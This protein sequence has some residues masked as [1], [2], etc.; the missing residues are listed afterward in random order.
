MSLNSI[1]DWI[2][3]VSGPE[4]IWFVKYLSG[5][6]TLANNT[7]Q[8]GPY[9]PN[10]ILFGLFPELLDEGVKN[11]DVLLDAFIDSHSDAKKV[12]VV[13]YNQGTRNEC[14]MTRWGGASSPMLDPE[15]TG[16]L[17]VFAFSRSDEE[18]IPVCRIW[19]CRHPLEEDIVEERV[20][21]VE[22]GK[23]GWRVWSRNNALQSHLLERVS[24]SRNS[25]HLEAGD[26]PPEWL[27]EFPSP[28]DIF[29]KSIEWGPDDRSNVDDRLIKRRRCE[30]EIFQS[31]EEAMTLPMVRNGFDN[32]NDFIATA[33]TVL[34]RR[35]A[36]AGRSLE[37]QVRQILIEE[38]LKEGRDFSWQPETERGK[39]PDFLFPSEASYK[40]TSF[41]SSKLQM[42]AVKT[43][44]RD[45]WR[46]VLNEADRIPVKHLLTVQEG[47]SLK[48]FN[49]M[50]EAGV[51]L[52]IPSPLTDRFPASIRANLQSLESFIGDVRLLL[53]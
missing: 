50:S 28:S 21:L 17:T 52:V 5:N 4:Y 13:W 53:T 29:N 32:L 16:A 25:C 40:D 51:K 23:N 18:G 43:T 34:Q 15:S 41:P 42:L 10:K 38:G 48:Q 26:I 2:D 9:I 3:D 37:L 47:I 14:R 45:R 39:N 31:I 1:L 44:A 24:T 33:Q 22:P 19:V 49:E 35:K 46:Q 36:R 20:G 8:A 27:D 12:R 6:D 7:H 30:F 11:P